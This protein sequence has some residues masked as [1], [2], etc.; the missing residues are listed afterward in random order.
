MLRDITVKQLS[1]GCL[2][3]FN[4]FASLFFEASTLKGSHVV[5]PFRLLSLYLII[6]ALET[7]DKVVKLR[8]GHLEILPIITLIVCQVVNI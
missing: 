2:G 1:L 3:L 6:T 4:L 5:V 8:D 7:F